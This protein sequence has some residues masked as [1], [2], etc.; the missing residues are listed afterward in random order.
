MIWETIDTAHMDRNK[1]NEL[2]GGKDLPSG[3]AEEHNSLCPCHEGAPLQ[4]CRQE[5]KRATTCLF[6]PLVHSFFLSNVFVLFQCAVSQRVTLSN[7]TLPYS[8]Q[9][10]SLHNCLFP[11]LPEYYVTKWLPLLQFLET[12]QYL[13]WSHTQEAEIQLQPAN[14]LEWDDTKTHTHTHKQSLSHLNTPVLRHTNHH[15]EET[16]PVGDTERRRPNAV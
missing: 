9:F 12:F 1:L 11:R 14:I 13:G 2:R 15:L 7:L 3:T 5:D 10:T 4:T 6:I 8:M 16:S